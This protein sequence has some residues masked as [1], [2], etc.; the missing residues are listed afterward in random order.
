MVQ[1]G[2]HGISGETVKDYWMKDRDVVLREAM[3]IRELEA[4]R[5]TAVTVGVALCPVF[6]NFLFW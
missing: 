1:V 4:Q 6:V 3:A 2:R 5:I